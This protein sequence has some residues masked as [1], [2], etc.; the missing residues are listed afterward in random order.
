MTYD[1]WAD[2]VDRLNM[3]F[4]RQQ[5]DELTAQVWYDTLC[6]YRGE[7]VGRA[8]ARCVGSTEFISCHALVEAIKDEQRERS[9]VRSTVLPL[10]ARKAA[11]HPEM[12]EIIELLKKA[13]AMPGDPG[14]GLRP[15]ARSRVDELIGYLDARLAE[16]TTAPRRDRPA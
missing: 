6:V 16:P 3:G 8:L 15:D 5:I 10:P 7:Q 2:L 12:R 1:E 13:T 4:P 11:P 14:Y 9:A